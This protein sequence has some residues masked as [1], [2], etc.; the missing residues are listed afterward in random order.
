MRG[1]KV[2]IGAFVI[3]LVWCF[4]I[5]ILSFKRLHETE[6]HHPTL[7][8]IEPHT[9]K[10]NPQAKPLNTDDFFLRYN[11]NLQNI[12]NN[13][14]IL[15]NI[16]RNP[17]TKVENPA[18]NTK[19]P[20]KFTGNTEFWNLTKHINSDIQKLNWFEKGKLIVKNNEKYLQQT[21]GRA[22]R[23]DSNISLV[24]GLF[25]LGRGD[26]QNSFN[27][28]FDHYIE[29]F[30]TFL[31]YQFLNII[32]IQKEHEALYQPYISKIDTEKYP[33]KIIYKS[34]DEIRAFPFFELI[35]GI[36]TDK[37]WASGGWLADSP[38]ATLELYNPMVMSKILWT[39]YAAELNPFNTDSF[40]WLDGLFFFTPFPSP[41]FLFFFFFSQFPFP[42]SLLCF[43][44]LPFHS[45]LFLSSSIP[46]FL[47][48]SI[49]YFSQFP[50]LLFTPFLS[51]SIFS[52]TFLFPLPPLPL[53]SRLWFAFL[54]VSIFLINL[55]NFHF[56]R[57]DI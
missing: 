2:I 3:I 40:L 8:N 12:Q 47:Y 45:L 53:P 32:F 18:T 46:L 23:D 48:S 26:L 34:M 5:S 39:A 25:D 43:L 35:Q 16:V 27:R 4:S 37:N 15:S 57:V 38:Q 11:N 50:P 42:F 6:I 31:Q 22:T 1:Q 36:R 14:N 55:P 41:L 19:T 21:I 17:A 54:P 44:P 29:R 33:I 30:S 20:V 10:L 56:L 13:D 51:S 52:Y 7:R 28:K 24:S 49:F 9:F